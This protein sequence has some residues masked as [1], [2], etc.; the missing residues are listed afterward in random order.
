MRF[1]LF[2]LLLFSVKGFP[3][4]TSWAELKESIKKESDKDK[5]LVLDFRQKKNLPLSFSDGRNHF[6][7]RAVYPSGKPIYLTTLNAGAATSSGAS[8][9]QNG[10]TGF[11]LDGISHHIFQWDAGLVKPHIEFQ[12]RVIA[13][14]GSDFHNHATH[15]AGILMA[16]GVNAQAKGMS[17][18]AKLHSYYFD[19]DIIEMASQ[20]ELNPYGFFISNHSYGSVTGWNK[21]NNTWTWNGDETVSNDEDFTAG[22]YSVRTKEIDQIAFLAPYHTIV[23]A[24]GN[25]RAD[26][27]TGS[28]PP[29]CN[30]GTGYDCIIQEGTAKNIITVGAVN[31]V[32]N[33][34]STAS[35]TMSTFSSWGPTDDG[36]IKPDLVGAGMNLFSTSSN[37]TDTYTTLSGTSMATPNVAGSLMLLQ[38]LYGKLNG[39]RWMKSATLKAL[40]IHTAKEAGA[41][42]GPDYSFG[43]GLIDV[44]EGARLISQQ[45]DENIFILERELR[46]DEPQ[47]FVLQP[48]A[49]K[50]VTATLVWNDPAGLPAG[51]VVD[52]PY[53]M[54]VNDLD[55]RIVDSN[56]AQKFPWILDPGSPASQTTRGDNIRDN[57][58]KIEFDFPEAKP[59]RLIVSNKGYLVNG[60]QS[61]SLVISYTSQ[62]ASKTFYWIGGSG[63]WDD[64]AHWSLASGGATVGIVPTQIDHVIVDENSFSGSG[65]IMLTSDVK[66]KSLRWWLTKT[67]GINFNGHDLEIKKEI[68][69]TSDGFQKLGNGNFVLSSLDSGRVNGSSSLTERPDLKFISGDWIMRGNLQVDSLTVSGGRVELEHAQLH[70]NHFSGMGSTQFTSNNSTIYLAKSWTSNAS[71]EITSQDSEIRI[72]SDTV[73]FNASNLVWA[74]TLSIMNSKVNV[75]GMIAFDLIFVGPASAILLSS[76]SVLTVNKGFASNGQAGVPVVFS[77]GNSSSLHLNFHK[78]LCFDFLNVTQVNLSGDAVVNLGS[79][80]TVQS[81]TGW[82]QQSCEQILFPDFEVQ[83]NCERSL[84]E[85]VNLSTGPVDSY[86]W[87]F[88]DQA[89]DQNESDEENPV[90]QFD[91]SDFSVTLTVSGNGKSVAYSKEISILTN[92]LPETQI[93]YNSET[94]FS[95]AE[96]P[97]YQWFINDQPLPGETN[98][99]YNYGGEEGTYRVVL[100]D[101]QCNSPSEVLL[102]TGVSTQAESS[103]QVYPNPVD[104]RLYFTGTGDEHLLI[105]DCLGRTIKVDWNAR[106]G[107]ADVSSLQSGL[108]VLVIRKGGEERIKKVLVKR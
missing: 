7:M 18:N 38:D 91:G 10:V 8:I 56:G 70:V 36:R 52:P 35:V 79:N 34:T 45:D 68:T 72:Q 83:Y 5:E 26:V 107:W 17:P 67:A 39:G 42:P 73:L 41:A 95:S 101:E 29:D 100:Y 81:S 90:H 43:W 53:S 61:Y 48:Q 62:S 94:M 4:N 33:Y 6:Y 19:D 75:L 15:V 85:F 87:N 99:I 92:T 64:P 23:W 3:Q 24:A 51:A 22:Y 102:I 32:L 96:A 104:D 89:S 28:H 88:G 93:E 1:T 31:K 25:D 103:W 30:G 106:E 86:H 65:N 49:N 40:A 57:V 16:S 44:A 55:I 97:N 71:I 76:G 54:L 74:G 78:K 9:I 105:K 66:C 84:T 21:S 20:A 77:G 50:K 82:L 2:I 108:Y 12:D 46:N 47:E 14:E 98:R 63:N 13:N 58:E 59:Y 27:G 60:V 80:S 37:G 11:S 69:F